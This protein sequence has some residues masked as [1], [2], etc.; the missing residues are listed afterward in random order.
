MQCIRARFRKRPRR[1]D[2]RRDDDRRGQDRDRR[3]DDDRRDDRRRGRDEDRRGRDD[4]RRG[5]ED[6]R[7]PDFI[8]R[9]GS[10][11]SDWGLHCFV[12]LRNFLQIKLHGL[13]SALASLFCRF[14]VRD[15]PA[16]T[17]GREIPKLY[18]IHKGTIVRVQDYG[19]FV[20]LGD[21][22]KYKECWEAVF[23]DL[24]GW[25]MFAGC[26]FTGHHFP[27]PKGSMLSPR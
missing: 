4:D 18:S 19:A 13:C 23:T 17:T 8:K 14:R 20:R 10:L 27:S 7:R 6:E 9:Q 21:G 22:S 24:V 5:R 26:S 16:R 25:W 2:D 11:G 15:R 3:R 1:D 12:K